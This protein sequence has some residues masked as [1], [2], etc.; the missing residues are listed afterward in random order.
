MAEGITTGLRVIGE[1]VW[2]FTHWNTTQ[3]F[4]VNDVKDID[5]VV[6]SARDPE[7]GSISRDSAHI[8]ATST[9]DL[10]FCNQLIVRKT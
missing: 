6:V 4:A 3:E 9:R 1:A 8:G 10:P 7:L 5:N 2:L